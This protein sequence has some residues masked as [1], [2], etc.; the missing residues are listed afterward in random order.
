MANN[1]ATI[2]Y[3]DGA[4]FNSGYMLRRGKVTRFRSH[5]PKTHKSFAAARREVSRLMGR[6]ALESG[7]S[8]DEEIQ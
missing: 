1:S 2:R 3:D 5:S 7:Y 8:T 4:D 6:D